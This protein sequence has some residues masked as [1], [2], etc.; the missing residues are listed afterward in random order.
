MSR[1]VKESIKK[2]TDPQMTQKKSRKKKLGRRTC[3]G[4]GAKEKKADGNPADAPPR[5]STAV[6]SA[7]AACDP[8]DGGLAAAVAS[9]VT[10][11]G[12][13]LSTDENPPPSS[14]AARIDTSEA[15]KVPLFLSSLIPR[16]TL[17]FPFCQFC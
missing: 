9:S 15:L 10:P 3:L 17:A 7:G 6:D 12:W 8:S 2:Q 1:R 14:I 5:A 11:L 4:A 16:Q 13:T